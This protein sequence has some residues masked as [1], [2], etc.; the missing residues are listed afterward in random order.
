MD[1]LWIIYPDLLGT[2]NINSPFRFSSSHPSPRMSF[3]ANRSSKWSSSSRKSGESHRA[4]RGFWE[5]LGAERSQKGI[6]TIEGQP[7][8]GP[9]PALQPH[10][11]WLYYIFLA[12]EDIKLCSRYSCTGHKG[13][14]RT[15]YVAGVKWLYYLLAQ[16]AIKLWHRTLYVAGAACSFLMSEYGKTVRLIIYIYINIFICICI[17][18]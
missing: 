16:E 2:N 7:A 18:M 11:K 5:T 14:H 3:V 17:F 9:A 15:L 6:Y 4:A 13:W 12:Q 1:N 8:L 10:V